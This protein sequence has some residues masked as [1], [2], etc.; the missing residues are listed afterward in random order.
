[1]T[2][3]GITPATS[4]L[5]AQRLNQLRQRASYTY[6]GVVVSQDVATHIRLP[7]RGRTLQCCWG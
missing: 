6:R 7:G 5:N 2:Q 1:M 4:R 3:S